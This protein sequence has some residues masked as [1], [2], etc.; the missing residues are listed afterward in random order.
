MKRAWKVT[1][2]VKTW[3]TECRALVS[4]AL[5]YLRPATDENKNM[6]AI[7]AKKLPPATAIAS[8]RRSS[9]RACGDGA[10]SCQA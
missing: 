2:Q 9:A 10:R 8:P 5:K 7:G 3:V 6:A 1:H 4:T